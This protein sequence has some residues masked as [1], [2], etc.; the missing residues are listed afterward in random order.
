MIEKVG[1]VPDSASRLAARRRLMTAKFCRDTQLPML[2]STSKC[3]TNV[4]NSLPYLRD[5]FPQGP[6]LS[7]PPNPSALT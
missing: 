4:V 6:E 7:R 5:S 3:Q 1:A 2:T